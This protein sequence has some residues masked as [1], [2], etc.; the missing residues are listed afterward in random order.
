MTTATSKNN[1]TPTNKNSDG[2]D[3]INKIMHNGN[4]TKIADSKASK[5]RRRAS[6]SNNMNKRIRK[7]KAKIFF[8]SRSLWLGDFKRP[9]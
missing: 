6:D 8:L 1:D 5:A 9:N 7:V 2:A 4:V 3:N